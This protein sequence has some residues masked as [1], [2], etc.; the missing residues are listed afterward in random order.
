MLSNLA[1]ALSVLA[2]GVAIVTLRLQ[3][4]PLDLA[5]LISKVNQIDLDLSELA[6]RQ[7][8]WMRRDATRTARAAKD[9]LVPPPLADP[10]TA[11]AD[12]RRRVAQLRGAPNL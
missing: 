12:L 2:L 7:N 4:V 1:L 5:R 6:D 9:Q 11:K 8:T 3:Q 10:V